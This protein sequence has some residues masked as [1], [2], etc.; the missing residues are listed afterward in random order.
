MI[1]IPLWVLI[2]LAAGTGGFLILLVN[3]IMREMRDLR[4]DIALAH[5]AQYEHAQAMARIDL[6]K[7]EKG[8]E[9]N[10]N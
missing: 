4:D 8:K 2:A 9:I 5:E 7:M 1:T 3:Y 10:D 6:K